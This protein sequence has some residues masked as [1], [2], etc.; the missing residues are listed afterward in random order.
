[1]IRKDQTPCLSHCLL[2]VTALI[3]LHPFPFGA[4][5]QLALAVWLRSGRTLSTILQGQLNQPQLGAEGRKARTLSYLVTLHC[6]LRGPG[7]N[8]YGIWLAAPIPLAVTI[9][10]AIPAGRREKR[11]RGGGG[12]SHCGLRAHKVCPAGLTESCLDIPSRDCV[13]LSC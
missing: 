13:T 3:Q 9:L 4:M 7:G 6:V 12:G 11:N 8:G 10:Y 2:H 1:M 5:T